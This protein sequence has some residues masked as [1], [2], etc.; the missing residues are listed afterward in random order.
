MKEGDF[1]ADL[2]LVL[3][4]YAVML[5]VGPAVAFLMGRRAALLLREKKAA[6]EE[7]L[8]RDA[9]VLLQARSEGVAF[10]AVQD[11]LELH[12]DEVERTSALRTFRAHA[13]GVELARRTTL[14]IG[15]PSGARRG[16]GARV[17]PLGQQIFGPRIEVRASDPDLA[18]TLLHTGTA[19]EALL[20]IFHAPLYG[21]AIELAEDGTLT[22]DVRLD[23]DPDVID[24]LRHRTR[25]LVEVLRENARLEARR[26]LPDGAARGALAGPSGA[27]VGVTPF[28]G[29]GRGERG[30]SESESRRA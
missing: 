4:L 7:A 21:L 14:Y 17:T 29:E 1:V 6:L 19:R 9:T 11:G 27:A 22:V 28:R 12:V 26:Q 30:E 3:F 10:T 23:Y 15:I 18:A 13:H 24:A 2:F 8:A 5:G 20:A 16:I 25:R